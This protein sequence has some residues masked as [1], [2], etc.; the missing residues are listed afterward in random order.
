MGGL[1]SS[2]PRTH[3]VFLIGVLAIAGF[4]GLSGFFSKDEILVAAWSADVPGHQWLYWIGLA[5]AGLT[6][7]YMF[8]LQIK[9]F[10]G[11]CHAPAEVRNQ[12]DDPA[13]TVINPLYVLAFFSV[14][15]GY[16][17]LPQ[18]WGDLIDLENSNSLANF[19]GP[20]LPAGEPHALDHSTEYWMAFG[21]VGMATAG[22][23]LAWWF[24]MRR[25]ALPERIAASAGGF[26][27][28][29]R[30]KY[31]VDEFYDAVIVRPLVRISEQ[32]LFRRVDAGLI[33][34]T[35]VNG[36]ARLVQG[37]AA[38]GLKYLQTGLAQSYILLMIVGAVAVVGYLIR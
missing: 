30:D 21:A 3:V 16:A 27:R 4:P 7:F 12:L 35:A 38:N 24:Y 20:V 10:Y 34:G 31:Y 5:T 22:A 28:L 32:V 1:Y 26:Y 15:A 8:R 29:L 33:D 14:I 13:A 6:A 9:T 37:L 18:V 25:P 11:E 19:L 17:G 36:T 23:L 2:I